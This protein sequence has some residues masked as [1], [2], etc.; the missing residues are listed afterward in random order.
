MS[1]H[2]YPD[3]LFSTIPALKTEQQGQL[4][5]KVQTEGYSAYNRPLFVLLFAHP[6]LQPS[7]NSQP[8]FESFLRPPPNTQPSRPSFLL[9]LSLTR[10]NYSPCSPASHTSTTHN[11]AHS[12]PSTP[13][14]P[15]HHTRSCLVITYVNETLRL[16]TPHHL[17]FPFYTILYSKYS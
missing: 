8:P 14:K 17:P 11:T 9:S 12:T 6:P 10:Q 2:T 16:P 5:R 13:P 7:L 1:N 15:T 3:P 4:G